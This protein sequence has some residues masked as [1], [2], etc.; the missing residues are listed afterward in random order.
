MKKL[1]LI[2]VILLLV[3]C[4]LRRGS[5]GGTT[6]YVGKIEN[7]LFELDADGTR[8]IALLTDAGIGLSCDF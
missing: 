3:G 1:L 4:N 6:E 2:P 5:I 8:C 7:K